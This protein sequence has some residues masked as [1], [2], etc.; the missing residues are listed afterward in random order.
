MVTLRLKNRNDTPSE[1]TQQ[2]NNEAQRRSQ[3]GLIDDPYKGVNVGMA[4]GKLFESQLLGD[5]SSKVVLESLQQTLS[6]TFKNAGVGENELNEAVKYIYYRSGNNKGERKW[7][8]SEM[9]MQSVFG[10]I[11][12]GNEKEKA[13]AYY[14][15]NDLL[16]SLGDKTRFPKLKVIPTFLLREVEF[17]MSLEI[18]RRSQP[19]INSKKFV[20]TLTS[21]LQ[22]KLTPG[23]KVKIISGLGTPMDYVQKIDFVVAIIGNKGEILR[24]YSYDLKTNPDV[25]ESLMKDVFIVIPEDLQ[26]TLE[27]RT[28]S[29]IDIVVQNVVERE[30]IVTPER[31]S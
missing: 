29:C 5:L 9:F 7:N 24:Y 28:R 31:G 16:R 30:L 13:E 11:K 18:A 26:A 17:N 27:E 6:E 4:T 12:S 8:S 22:Q 23:T 21:E 19:E 14:D 25:E 20:T 15:L 3:S 1:Q 2:Q 10:G